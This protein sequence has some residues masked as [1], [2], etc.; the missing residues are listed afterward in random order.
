MARRFEVDNINLDAYE[1][2]PFI[3]EKYIGF[4]IKW[5]SDIGFGEYTIYK[6][7]GSDKWQADSEHM[8][9]HEDKAFLNELLRQFVGAIEI[10]D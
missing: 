3:N 6:A 8:D 9:N 10:I 5:D 2:E 4:V 7:V 1:V